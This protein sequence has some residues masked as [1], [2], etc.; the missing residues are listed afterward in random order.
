MGYGGHSA[1]ATPTPKRFKSKWS[2]CPYHFHKNNRAVK[3]GDG[4]QVMD[5]LTC[6]LSN[7]GT[8]EGRVWGAGSLS[9]IKRVSGGMAK[10]S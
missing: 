4:L 8:R 2:R 10:G 3:D 5:A 7:Q 1:P 9:A 6:G